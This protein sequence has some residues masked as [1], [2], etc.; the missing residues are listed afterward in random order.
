M[1][2][3]VKVF[4]RYQP[5]ENLLLVFM[6][7]KCARRGGAVCV[8]VCVCVR[9]RVRVRARATEGE[10]GKEMQLNEYAACFK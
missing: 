9:V 6:E 4:T 7:T 10:Q 8:C 2:D 1:C 5:F 3:C